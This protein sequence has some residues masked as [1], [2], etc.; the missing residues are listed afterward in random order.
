[1]AVAAHNSVAPLQVRLGDVRGEL[2]FGRGVAEL[3]FDQAEQQVA[4][5]SSRL[6]RVRADGVPDIVGKPLFLLWAILWVLP[7]AKLVEHPL[8]ARVVHP[9][10]L[11][12]HADPAALR[13][14]LGALL[15]LQVRVVPFQALRA[16]GYQT[17]PAL[18]VVL[19]ALA[20]VAA[21]PPMA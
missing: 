14:A 19:P 15:P 17:V 4:L 20:V 8:H 13:A 12:A 18:H 10:V 21:G 16:V 2:A 6:P 9:E 5:R 7:D 11:L 3:L 1:V